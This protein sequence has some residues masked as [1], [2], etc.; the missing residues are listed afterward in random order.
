MKII[1]NCLFKVR[2]YKLPLTNPFSGKELN[3]KIELSCL[4]KNYTDDNLITNPYSGKK[5]E[6]ENIMRENILENYF[7]DFKV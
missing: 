4:I 6:I 2:N 1:Q 3:N 5:I 7:P